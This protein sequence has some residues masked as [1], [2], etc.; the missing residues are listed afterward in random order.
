MLLL[1][2][3]VQIAVVPWFAVRCSFL[4][5]GIGIAWTENMEIVRLGGFLISTLGAG[6][7][8]ESGGLLSLLFRNR[9]VLA[10]VQRGI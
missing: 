4:E 10:A 9:R 8:A 3:C 1:G 6:R 2:P 7:L 5:Q